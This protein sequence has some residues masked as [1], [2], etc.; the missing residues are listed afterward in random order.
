MTEKE[1]MKTAKRGCSA[2]L[3]LRV[4]AGVATIFA[5]AVAWTCLKILRIA[6]VVGT[7]VLWVKP[8]FPAFANRRPVRAALPATVRAVVRVYRSAGGIF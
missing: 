8:V 5:I 2:Q 4:V 1:L 7:S 6:E 3:V